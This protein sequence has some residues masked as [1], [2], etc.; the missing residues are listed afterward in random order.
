MNCRHCKESLSNVFINLGH[1]PPSNN[2]LG[3]HELLQKEISFPLKLYV[4]TNC[5]LVQTHDY[6]NSQDLFKSDYAY[7][8]STSKSWLDHASIFADKITNLLKLD[9]DTFVIEIASND[10]YLL[11][12]FLRKQIP[13]LGIEPTEGTAKAAEKLG[14][15]VLKQFFGS[16]LAEKLSTEGTKADLLI[17]NNVY[18]HVPDLNDFSLGIKKILNKNG[19]V[20]IEFQ[21]VLELIKN[22][23]F[24]TIYHEHFSYLSLYTVTTI[25]KSV[26]LKV[27]DV[28]KLSTSYT[29]KALILRYTM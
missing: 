15:K 27:Y 13:C 5:W 10:G 2:Y 1:A 3:A 29:L 28:E 4:C 8:S 26:D 22:K 9:K 14:I 17:A 11:K 21:H 16:D 12:N 18:A 20:T 23:Q 6:A 19:T 24:D 25:F 7:Y